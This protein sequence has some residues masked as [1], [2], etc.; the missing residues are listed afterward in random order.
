MSDQDAFGRVLASLHDAMLD[1]THWPAASALIDE[2]CGVIRNALLVGEGPPGDIQPHFVGFYEWGERREDLEHDYLTDYYPI[3]ERVQHIRQ[4]PDSRVVHITDL[5]TE[6]ELKTSRA[7]NEGMRRCRAQDSVNVRLDGPEGSHIVWSINDPVASNGRE[8]TH[9]ALIKGLLPHIRQF[10][11]VRQ[12]LAKAEALGASVIDLLN[13]PRIGVVHLDRRGKVLEVNDRA[14][15]MLQ[16]SNALSC[17]AGALCASQPAAHARL[18]QL[19][20][21]ALSPSSAVSGSMTLHS[22]FSSPPFVVHVKPVGVRQIDFGARR[23]AALVLIVEPGHKTR[24]DPSL[25]AKVLKLTPM[26]SEVAVWLAAGWT[27]RKIAMTTRRTE[28]AIHW[29]LRH[30]YQKLG[31]SRQADLVRLVLSLAEFA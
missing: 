13:N 31:I 18:E 28:G 25:V 19:L 16:N 11:R 2:A 4:L 5:Y 6:Q 27:V 17:R 7:Y 30:I 26:E 24:I 21:E 14:R 15:A 12:A 1:D 22:G 23:V 3:D 10:A 8:S 20:A 29:H 9:L